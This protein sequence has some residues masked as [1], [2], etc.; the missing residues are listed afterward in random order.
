MSHFYQRL[1]DVFATEDEPKVA[2]RRTIEVLLEPSPEVL[3]VGVEPQQWRAAIEA[4]LASIDAADDVE[5]ATEVAVWRQRWP[6]T[7]RE[8]DALGCR[9]WQLDSN[10]HRWRIEGPGVDADLD[11]GTGEILGLEG[12]LFGGKAPFDELVEA[13]DRRVRQKHRAEA[14]KARRR[15]LRKT[16]NWDNHRKRWAPKSGAGALLKGGA[17]AGH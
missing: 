10:G 15:E 7:R 14:E 2:A 6:A 4:L 11:I 16:H 3:E 13:V 17:D 8:L 1:A 9:S 12:D 5:R